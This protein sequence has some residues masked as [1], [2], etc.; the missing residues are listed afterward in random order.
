MREKNRESI[1][2]DGIEDVRDG[3]LVYTDEL[4]A[5]VRKAFDVDL[6]KTVSLDE[7]ED[8]CDFLINKVIKPGI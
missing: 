7:V 3:V 2:L 4:I 5:K 1:Y 6:R 8:S